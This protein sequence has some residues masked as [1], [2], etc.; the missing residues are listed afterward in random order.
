[1]DTDAGAM[2]Q[3]VVPGSPADKAGIQAGDATVTV[4]GQRIKTG[5]D[6]IVAADG[7]PVTSMSDVISA[8]DSKQPG[9]DLKLTVLRG[10][11]QHDVTIQLGNRPASAQG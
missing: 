5:G 6:V 1:L 11:Q 4:A 10:G 7:K 9:D 8:V 3:S 2:V